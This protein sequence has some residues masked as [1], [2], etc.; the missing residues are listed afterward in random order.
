MSSMI[1]LAFEHLSSSD[2]C[3]LKSLQPYVQHSF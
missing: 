1:N 2:V 3:K